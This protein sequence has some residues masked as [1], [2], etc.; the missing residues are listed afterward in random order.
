MT[1]YLCPSVSPS[2][3]QNTGNNYLGGLLANPSEAILVENTQQVK[4][5]FLP[6]HMWGN[7]GSKKG[8]GIKWG[9]ELPEFLQ[10]CAQAKMR[11]SVFFPSS[12]IF[13]E[14]GYQSCGLLLE[15]KL[16]SEPHQKGLALPAPS[17]YPLLPSPHN[18][19]CSFSRRT[20]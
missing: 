17:P 19:S 20:I 10:H 18:G 14:N 8:K 16:G 6:F 11:L 2:A 15:V 3:Q 5:L 4:L 13:P 9:P 12:T 7:T 1:L